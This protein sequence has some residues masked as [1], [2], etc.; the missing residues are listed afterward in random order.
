VHE[1]R[2]SALTVAELHQIAAQTREASA[3]GRSA[4][5]VLRELLEGCTVVSVDAELAALAGRIATAT[6]LPS[7]D[8]V[9]LATARRDG[10]RLLSRHVGY[11]VDAAEVVVPYDA[12]EAARHIGPK[13][14]PDVDPSASPRRTGAS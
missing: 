10:V 5:A 2:V 11:G 9:V 13:V 6:G 12:D 4:E 3:D 1:V 8:T 7:W 14:A